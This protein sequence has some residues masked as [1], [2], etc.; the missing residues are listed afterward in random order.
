MKVY[1]AFLSA[2]SELLQSHW[3]NR[4]AARASSAEN[5]KIHVELLFSSRDTPGE[6]L[7]ESCSI[8]HGNKVFLQEKRFSRSNWEFRRI[9][10]SEAQAE[11]VKEWCASR[12]GDSFNHLG[13]YTTPVGC[14]KPT[15]LYNIGL[16]KT[17]QWFCSEVVSH[18]L[19]QVGVIPAVSV[20]PQKL[21]DMLQ[22]ITVVDSARSSEG[23]KF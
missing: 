15:S 3:L 13:F 12:V 7:G 17:P 1:C 5:P 21:F 22:D 19:S 2:D 23:I 11:T 10:M 20:H 16:A 9:P 6:I 8:T 14:V 18:A 4:L